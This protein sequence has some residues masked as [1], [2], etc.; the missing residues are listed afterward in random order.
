M[1]VGKV[2][3]SP[4]IEAGPGEGRVRADSWDSPYFHDGLKHERFLRTK[5][6]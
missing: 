3:H 6:M 2:E 5:K 1:G 4:E